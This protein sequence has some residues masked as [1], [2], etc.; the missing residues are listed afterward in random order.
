MPL[1]PVIPQEKNAT[2]YIKQAGFSLLEILIAITL[3]ALIGG[4]VV[5]KVF[6]SLHEGRVNTAVV[7]MQSFAAALNDFR[8]HCGRYPTTEQTL[9]AL[10]NKPAGLECNR[11]NPNGYIEAESIPLDPWEG[12][13]AYESDG[14]TF[15]IISY[16]NDRL[17]G[18]EGEDTDIPL[19]KAKG[20]NTEPADNAESSEPTEP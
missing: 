1:F 15:N 11:Y 12:D 2:F 13:Y 10:L 20:G 8:R 5:T 19:N 7:Q 16:G 14:K 17:P 4:L 6:D 3:M 18:G 9:D